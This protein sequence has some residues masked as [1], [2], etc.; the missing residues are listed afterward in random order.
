MNVIAY[1]HGWVG[2]G[3]AAALVADPDIN[4]TFVKYP[5]AQFTDEFPCRAAGAVEANTLYFIWPCKPYPDGADAV[6]TANWRHILPSNFYAAR[7]GGF[8]IHNSLL[9]QYKGRRPLQRALEAGDQVVG[10]TIHR[11]SD[12]IDSGEILHQ[13]AFHVRG[14]ENLY[15][16]F[17]LFAGHDLLRV[18]KE[19][20]ERPR[21]TASGN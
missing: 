9:P 21:T 17:G 20:H 4:P 19:Q 7:L 15:H 10:Y 11:L 3:V 16:A 2:A 14:E 5:E 1:V 13:R 6:V 8:N 12:K 18:L